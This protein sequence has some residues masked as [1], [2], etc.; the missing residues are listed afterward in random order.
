[1]IQSAL[2]IHSKQIAQLHYSTINTGSLTR[3]GIGFLSALY[4]YL[5]KNEIVLVAV[6]E[7]LV[8]GFVSCSL[9]ADIVIWRFLLNPLCVLR[10]VIA[11]ISRPSMLISS[12]ETFLIPVK[13]RSGEKIRGVK[14]LPKVELLSISVDPNY[15]KDGIGTKLLAELEKRLHEN[16][17]KQFKV[18]AGSKLTNANYFYRKSG[19]KLVTTIKI[20]GGEISNVY[21]KEL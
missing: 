6:E 5:I 15:Q 18:V 20:H 11:L 19:F 12:I 9:N 17:I 1:M 16:E 3:L 7:N 2:I 13:H 10:F 21:C 8:R 14:Q 4:K